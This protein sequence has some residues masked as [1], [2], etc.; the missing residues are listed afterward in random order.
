MRFDREP[1]L[2]RMEKGRSRLD[3]LSQ[4]QS[5][6]IRWVTNFSHHA[7]RKPEPIQ[8]LLPLSTSERV[9]RSDSD[10]H[11]TVV[12]PDGELTHMGSGGMTGGVSEQEL[13]AIRDQQ[14]EHYVVTGTLYSCRENIN[15]IHEIFRQV[16]Y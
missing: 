10:R 5:T 14:L 6:V 11:V 16:S 4:C 8:A 15:L 1:V 12:G 7:A 13:A 9:E 3:S 2:E